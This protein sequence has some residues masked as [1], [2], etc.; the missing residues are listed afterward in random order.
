MSSPFIQINGLQCGDLIAYGGRVDSGGDLSLDNV[1]S[2][3]QEIASIYRKGRNPRK[4]V[5][6]TKPL[7]DTD[8]DTILSEVNSAPKGSEFYPSRND[9]SVYIDRCWANVIDPK[10]G[11]LPGGWQNASIAEITIISRE[12]WLYGPQQGLLTAQNV[13]LPAVSALLTNNSNLQKNGNTNDEIST[14]NGLDYLQA[15]GKYDGTLGYVQNLSCRIT[16]GSSSV[17][18][19]KQILL[20]SKLMA[21]D[22][23][24]LDR[25]GNVE[26]SY[27]SY[28]A[29]TYA[30]LQQ[31]LQGATYCS[32]GSIAAAILTIGNNGKIIFP[33][34]G[35]LPLKRVF[36]QIDVTA[37]TGTPTIQ[38]GYASALSDL[39]A[40]TFT[41]VLGT[42]LIQI[43]FS[44]GATDVFFGVVCGASD[45]ISLSHVLTKADR[46]VAPSAI[47]GVDPTSTFRIRVENSGGYGVL[48][49]LQATYRD[50]FWY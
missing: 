37:I 27:E 26:H 14:N 23:F 34:L 28:F 43:P 32:G 33:C 6:R 49:S 29:Q 36:L 9:R 16:P 12:P 40:I 17:E 38:I 8:L 45:A 10:E 7:S 19:D 48:Q 46:Y 35:P 47:K 31:D 15:S 39:A 13:T 20:C 3:F 1:P 2:P 22:I 4:W 11:G 50:I 30:G 44:I 21:N 5:Y 24:V 25:Y 41:P 18:L 42:N